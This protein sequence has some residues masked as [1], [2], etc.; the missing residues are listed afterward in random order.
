LALGV[1]IDG[2][3]N[4][5][6]K[7]SAPFTEKTNKTNNSPCKALIKSFNIIKG[8]NSKSPAKS[9]AKSPKVQE[10]K[11]ISAYLRLEKQSHIDL[12]LSSMQNRFT[13]QRSLAE[14]PID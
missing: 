2:T 14:E 12:K 3:K 4:K 7:F 13:L 10:P 5:G 11:D 1:A 8:S 9:V 6:P